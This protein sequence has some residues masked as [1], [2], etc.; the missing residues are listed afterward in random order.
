MEQL[1][2][3]SSGFR[4][5]GTNYAGAREQGCSEVKVVPE[6]TYA[7]FLLPSEV[8]QEEDD[9]CQLLYHHG[10]AAAS[11]MSTVKRLR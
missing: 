8:N 3:G 11:P 10:A 5:S 2:T 7:C 6:S 9:H 4:R 1:I